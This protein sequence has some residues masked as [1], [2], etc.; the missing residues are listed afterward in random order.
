[1]FSASLA[2]SSRE[3]HINDSNASYFAS[4]V[5]VD[6]DPKSRGRIPRDY[7]KE[8][9]G[10]LSYAAPFALPLI[11]RSEWPDRI[12]ELERRKT[13]LS[14]IVRYRKVPSLDQNGT[15]YCWCNAVITAIYALRAAAGLPFIALSPASVAA[16]IKNGRN[17]GG[18]GAQDRK[19]TRLNSSHTDISRMPSSA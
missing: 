19:S 4:S 17:E 10:S 14:D 12:E 5:I 7:E 18:W 8:P 13:R 3:I 11:P 16:P 9:H 1:M 15:N 6:G 2:L